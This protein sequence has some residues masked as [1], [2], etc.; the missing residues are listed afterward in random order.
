M[1][2]GSVLCR[3][4]SRAP[5]HCGAWRLP[6]SP[7][8]AGLVCMC[9][10]RSVDLLTAAGA[11]SGLGS[12]VSACAVAHARSAFSPAGAAPWVCA[13]VAWCTH[14]SVP[15]WTLWIKPR[16]GWTCASAMTPLLLME[17]F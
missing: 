12:L 15:C 13:A 7:G 3:A 1:G 17:L 4:A 16:M 9:E 11:W 6:L 2:L 10:A 5:M 8:G 14:A